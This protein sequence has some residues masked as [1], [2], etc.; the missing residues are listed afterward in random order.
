MVM[1]FGL[2]RVARELSSA[3]A[4]VAAGI[5]LQLQG[6]TKWISIIKNV[7]IPDL[8]FQDS[9]SLML[10]VLSVDAQIF[11]RR[12]AGRGRAAEKAQNQP[13]PPLLSQKKAIS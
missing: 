3:G 11:S 5:L 4:A 10:S 6:R 8:D 12:S 7:T 13:A 2:A 9:E 1:F